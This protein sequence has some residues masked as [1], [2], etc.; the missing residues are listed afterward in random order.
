MEKIFWIVLVLVAGAMLPV[1]AGLNNQMGKALASPAWAVLISFFVGTIAMLAY[2]AV[3][4]QPLQLQTLKDVPL[5]AWIA[6]I[7]GAVYVTSV[8]LAFPKL[9]AALTFGLIVGGQLTISLLLDH[10]N[11]LVQ[12]PHQVNWYR[13][14]GMILIIA[15]VVII[16]KF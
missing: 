2:V 10:F 7:L 8:V 3:T 5:S 15:G 6:G 16:R 9:G 12:A 11:I 14:V 4:K 1:Q 13:V